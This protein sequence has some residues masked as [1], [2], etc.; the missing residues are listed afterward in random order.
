MNLLFVTKWDDYYECPKVD[1]YEDGRNELVT[2]AIPLNPKMQV[3]D[4]DGKLITDDTARRV[5]YASMIAVELQ[6]DSYKLEPY[7]IDAIVE[8]LLQRDNF[9]AFLKKME[10]L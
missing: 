5:G 3:T 4:E 2:S 9:T 6:N 8:F 7:Q 10:E 1:V